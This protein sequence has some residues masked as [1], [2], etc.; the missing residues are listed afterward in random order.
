MTFDQI[1]VGEEFQVLPEAKVATRN[2]I[3]LV[4]RKETHSHGKV[5]EAPGRSGDYYVLGEYLYF[6]G[7]TPVRRHTS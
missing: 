7:D 5:M 6:E 2:M 4:L 3:S 1:R